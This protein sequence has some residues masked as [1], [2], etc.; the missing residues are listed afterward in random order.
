[1]LVCAV[2]LVVGLERRT[3]AA[4]ETM[5]ALKSRQAELARQVPGP[6]TSNGLPPSMQ[7]LAERRLLERTRA[8]RNAPTELPDTSALLT[9]VLTA[10][11]RDVHAT[12]ESVNV[13]A[14]SIAI[15]A[16]VPSMV[17]AQR[18]ADAFAGLA[19]W[20]LLQP[21]TQSQRGAVLVIVRLTAMES[22]P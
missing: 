17:D 18:F 9:R 3:V 4:Y 16:S 13:S 21:Q 7:L 11:P 22:S 6:G 14:E 20:R 1:M 15:R 8:V 2:P 19:G 12:A 5:D 10:W